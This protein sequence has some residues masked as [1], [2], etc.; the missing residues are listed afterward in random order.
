M[1]P[2]PP[3]KATTS[4]SLQQVDGEEQVVEWME[5]M[6]ESWTATCT[7]YPQPETPVTGYWLLGVLV[8]GAETEGTEQIPELGETY[9]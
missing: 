1:L 7:F 9:G 2:A 8:E 6:A 3:W 5:V 4:D